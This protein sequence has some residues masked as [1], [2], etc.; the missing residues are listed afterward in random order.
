VKKQRN[1]SQ[2][3]SYDGL[4]PVSWSVERLGSG[5]LI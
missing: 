3:R 1:E 4:T 5:Y 2:A